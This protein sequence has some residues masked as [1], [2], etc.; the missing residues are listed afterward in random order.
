MKSLTKQI[1][2]KMRLTPNDVFFPSDFFDF[3]NQIRVN[4]T[5]SRM[6]EN[7]QI[8]RLVRGIYTIFS[9]NEFGKAL[10]YSELLVASF[11]RKTGMIITEIGAAA[12][13]TL[14]FSTQ[15]IT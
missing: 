12:A 14:G 3:A 1:E 15:N 5:L 7:E 6:V 11:A 8:W 10:A 2:D 4:K 13:N 9:I